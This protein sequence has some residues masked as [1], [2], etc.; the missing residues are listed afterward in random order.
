MLS[1]AMVIPLISGGLNLAIIA[2]TNQSALLMAFIMKS[3]MPAGAAGV[4]VALVVALALAAGFVLCLHRRSRPARS[5]PIT[6]VH[7]ILVTLGMMSLVD[8]VS[9]YLTRGT[10]ISGFPEPCCSG[11]ATRCW[12]CRCRSSCSSSL[13]PSWS[14]HVLLTRTRSASR[15]T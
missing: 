12:A 3:L 6:G 4:E 9:V 10:V 7:P 15:S 8:G 11:S 5:S 14:A 2:T 13:R 1:L